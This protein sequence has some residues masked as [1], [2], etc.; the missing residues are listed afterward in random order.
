MEHSP[1]DYFSVLGQ[2]QVF[3]ASNT[4]GHGAPAPVLELTDNDWH[5]QHYQSKIALNAP[6]LSLSDVNY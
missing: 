3:A 5:K 6:L 4:T 2:L 1:N